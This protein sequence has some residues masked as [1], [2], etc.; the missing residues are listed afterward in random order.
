MPTLFVLDIPE[1]GPLADFAEG[2]AELVVTA[3]GNYRKIH[4]AGEI[5]ISRPATGL[6]AAV[7]FGAL[8]G[9][10]E[11]KILEFNE[12]QLVIGPDG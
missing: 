1:Y 7:W 11:G 10:F 9:G 3:L 2:R 6:G 5:V 12:T 4:A 8:V